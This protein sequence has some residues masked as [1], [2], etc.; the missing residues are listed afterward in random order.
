MDTL[1]FILAFESGD[2]TD[3]E[4]IEGFQA[5]IDDGIVWTLQG[6]Y[7]RTACSLID[8]GLCHEKQN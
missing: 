1:D 3:K 6:F 8:E 2:V 5:L 7:G 4:L